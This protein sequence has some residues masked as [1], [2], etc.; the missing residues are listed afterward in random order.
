MVLMD[1]LA[2]VF[3]LRSLVRRGG[4]AGPARR[5]RTPARTARPPAAQRA[6][7]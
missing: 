4:R 3:C 7:A 1:V 2:R 5:G 6:A